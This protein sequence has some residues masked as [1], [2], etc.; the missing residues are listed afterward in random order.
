MPSRLSVVA[1][2]LFWCGTAAWV[3]Y[4]D[5]WPRVFSTGPPPVAVDVSDEASQL[6]AVQWTV[7]RGGENVGRLTTRTFYTDADD[8]FEFTHEYTNLRTAVGGVQLSVPKLSTAT[9]VTR[10]GTLRAQ[11]MSGRLEAGVGG[12]KLDAEMTVTGR[13][14]NGQFVGECEITSPLPMLNLKR[15]LDPVPVPNGHAL[16][17]L[18][19][20][21]RVTGIRAGQRWVVHEVNP[22]SEAVAL[23]LRAQ[24]GKTGFGLP[25]R[26][27]VQLV[28]EVL[29]APQ[30]VPW[31]DRQ[32][33]CWVIEYRDAEPKA[34]TWVRVSDGK[35]LKQEAFDG[36][37]HLTV[38]RDE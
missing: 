11:R 20:V 13:V 5:V 32:E 8:T 2:V 9:R 1:I 19:V 17:P 36:G 16:N 27:R 37:E 12:L 4:R 38:L 18:Q 15:P 34:R 6:L 28:A 31:R 25:E 35:V 29:S 3:V 23:M 24:L 26:K 10:A 22:L 33:P 30:P 7:L 21:N 14:E